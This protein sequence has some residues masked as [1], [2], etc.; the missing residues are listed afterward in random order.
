LYWNQES[1]E[2]SKIK[3][4]IP[5]ISFFISTMNDLLTNE[6]KTM[7]NQ[8]DTAHFIFN[9]TTYLDC[10]LCRDNFELNGSL[11][12]LREVYLKRPAVLF[13][14]GYTH[15]IGSYL[16]ILLRAYLG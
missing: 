15:E 14:G 7:D 4:F 12:E 5:G 9:I 1:G 3:V 10:R 2:R 11:V 8:Q 13:G 16:H 6:N